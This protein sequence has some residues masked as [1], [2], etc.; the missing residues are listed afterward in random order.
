[1]KVD[2]ITP[3]QVRAW[4]DSLDA[5]K[6]TQRQHAYALL[7]SIMAACVAEELISSTRAGCG[8]PASERRLG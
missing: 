6:P 1:M 5:D 4:F 2:E 8:L 7:K 3:R